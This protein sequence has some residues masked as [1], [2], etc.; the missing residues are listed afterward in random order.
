[1]TALATFIGGWE[2][3]LIAAV[4]GVLISGPL[5]VG[6]RGR[7]S[8]AQG[9]ALGAT[10]RKRTSPARAKH[11]ARC[12]ALSGLDS[13]TNAN[14]G[15]CP[16]LTNDAPLGLTHGHAERATTYLTIWAKVNYA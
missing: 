14:P 9:K 11:T 5:V 1:M 8:S 13:Q 7:H 3:L 6:L 10:S 2:L 12:A 15:L 16:G 4:L